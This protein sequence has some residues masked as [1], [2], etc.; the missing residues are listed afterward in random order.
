MVIDGEEQVFTAQAATA[1]RVA[2][3]IG[4]FHPTVNIFGLLEDGSLILISLTFEDV[5]F[6]PG[7]PKFHGAATLGA[8]LR[9]VNGT[10]QILGMLSDG[11]IILEAA[12]T[13]EGARVTGEV[14]S[15]WLSL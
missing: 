2:D 5:E 7:S 15:V 4:L 14:T 9:I 11:V 3:I 6:K 10:P 1:G 12:G 13:E 8:V